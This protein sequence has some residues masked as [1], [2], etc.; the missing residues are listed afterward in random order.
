[1]GG[2]QQ[3]AECSSVGQCISS[4]S[5]TLTN[6]TFSQDAST[7]IYNGSAPYI[8]SFKPNE[9]LST[10]V[11]EEIN[12]D[13]ELH[14]INVSSNLINVSNIKA[15]ITYDA[16]TGGTTYTEEN[17]LI[18]SPSDQSN[19]TIS[20]NSTGIVSI[21]VSLPSGKGIEDLDF[22]LSLNGGRY[23]H[24]R[25]LTVTVDIG[26]ANNAQL[27]FRGD[28]ISG[29]G[30]SYSKNQSTMFK[31]R[32]DQESDNNYDNLLMQAQRIDSSDN[33]GNL[34]IFNNQSLNEFRIYIFNSSTNDIVVDRA[35]TKVYIK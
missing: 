6:T 13:W 8:G 25:Y 24:L 20:G 7:F 4:N 5:N 10:F 12:G 19:Q 35:N 11:N 22:E 34:N 21:P 14:V 26:N 28:Q 33:N 15:D 18:F 2:D 31:A 3:N 16:V 9:S 30:I 17:N 32:F 27:V 29:G 23:D 1:M